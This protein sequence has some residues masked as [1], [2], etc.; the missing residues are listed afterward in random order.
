M[1]PSNGQNLWQPQESEVQTAPQPSVE[2]QTSQLDTVSWEASESIHHERDG[3][4]FVGFIVIFLSLIGVSIWL[5]QWTFTVLLAV[6]AVALVVY[7]K[8]PPRVLRYNL[9]DTGLQVGEQFYNFSNFR[10]FGVLQEGNI[11]SVML[12]PTKR[13]GQ[14]LTV[15]F[16][17]NDGEKIVDILGTHLP[18]EDLHIDIL[19]TILRRL[20]L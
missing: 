12:V 16:A 8:R 10:S 20:R 3:M 6:M 5:Q 14:G 13:F 1:Q 17:E 18:M 2:Q 4:W 9:T 15:Y 7:I 19:D 11:F